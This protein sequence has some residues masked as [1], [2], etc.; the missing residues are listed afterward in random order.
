DGF[1]SVHTEATWEP[2]GV[3]DLLHVIAVIAYVLNSKIVKYIF[4]LIESKHTVWILLILF[5]RLLR[6][7][8]LLLISKLAEGTNN[9][10]MLFSDN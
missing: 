5:A 6:M 2:F 8:C 10:A 9:L 7:Y 1:S 4:L 3:N